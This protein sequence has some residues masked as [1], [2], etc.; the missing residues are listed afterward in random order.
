[1]KKNITKRNMGVDITVYTL[2]CISLSAKA[3]QA[4]FQGLGTLPTGGQ[5]YAYT[6]SS[7]GTVVAGLAS[8][9]MG[10]FLAMRWT[11][12]D[13]M[14]N[15]GALPGPFSDSR[16]SG[17][18]FD[19]SVLVGFSNSDTGV[20][21]IRWTSEDGMVS[22]GRLTPTSVYSLA[23]DVSADGTIV[24]GFDEKPSFL[25]EAFRWSSEEGMV[26][27]GFPSGGA[28]SWASGISSDGSTIVGTSLS[29]L[30]PQ[31]FRW[32]NE[33][34]ML[35][36]GDLSGGPFNSLASA[37]S[38]DGSVVVGR[39][40]TIDDPEAMRWTANGGMIGLGVLPGNDHGSVA[41]SVSADGSIVVG[42]SNTNS[43]SESKAFI[44]DEVNGMR[45]LR[46]LLVNEYGLNLSG[47]LLTNA[48]DIDDDGLIIVGGGLNTAISS[49]TP[50]AWMVK[51]P[52]SCAADTDDSGAVNVTD[53]LELLAHWGL[54]PPPCPSDIII[55]GAVNVMD[56][57][58]L[59][60]S[61][62]VC[63]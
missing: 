32:T 9:G 1:M 40:W 29:S 49:I 39:G 19:G 35:G 22:L 53:L 17:A 11:E 54:C 45:N 10:F 26:G 6:V 62:G 51:L 30:G 4:T 56:L 36:L 24:V 60:E 12:I 27:L 43:S 37:A 46:S 48:W 13:G 38:S 14:I 3:Q 2:L 7:D 61:W 44:W 33:E 34:G 25:R 5:S 52:D 55:D 23:G 21:A 59:L 28:S 57:L 63:P 47:W 18:S 58:E 8:D 20:V 42:H 15:L 41:T 50:V 16:I 31:A